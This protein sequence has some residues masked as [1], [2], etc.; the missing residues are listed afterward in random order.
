MNLWL[1]VVIVGTVMACGCLYLSGEPEEEGELSY[2][3]SDPQAT[4]DVVFCPRDNCTRLFSG[5]ISESSS[6]DCALYDIDLQEIMASLDMKEARL[7]VDENNKEPV[8]RSVDQVRFD[9]SSQLSHNK[10]CVFDEEVVMTGSWNPTYNGAYRNNN[11]VIVIR[12]KL[13]AKNYMQEFDELWAGKHGGGATVRI[14]LS[15]L[16][17]TLVENYFCPEDSCKEHVFEA[18]ESAKESIIFMAFSFTDSDIA[19]LL[20]KKQGEGIRVSGVLEERRTSMK[21][22]VHDELVIAGIGVATDNN[23]YIMHH[24]VFIIDSRTVITGSYNPTKSADSRNDENIIMIHDKGLARQF[25]EEY[26]RLI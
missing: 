18:L 2:V 9:T 23:P 1:H 10:F 13:I 3:P 21:Y 14:P 17:S 22:N 4:I 25:Y 20:E 11:N 5:L 7:V 6:V 26:T 19:D 16:N 12:S 15:R 8:S 24:K